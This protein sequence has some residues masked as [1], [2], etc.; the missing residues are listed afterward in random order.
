MEFV[1]D[2]TFGSRS[3]GINGEDA[4]SGMGSEVRERVI[5]VLLVLKC[6]ISIKLVVFPTKP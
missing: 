5:C 4:A 6:K 2:L 1:K 3:M